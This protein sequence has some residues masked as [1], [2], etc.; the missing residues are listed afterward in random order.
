MLAPEVTNRCGCPCA[1][2]ETAHAV[3]TLHAGSNT[4]QTIH[5]TWLFYV[6][7][8]YILYSIGLSMVIEAKQLDK[9]FIRSLGGITLGEPKTVT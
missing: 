8:Y 2:G 9:G 5:Y 4:Y 3:K 1:M 6:V 7:L